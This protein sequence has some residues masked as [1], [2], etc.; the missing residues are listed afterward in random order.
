MKPMQKTILGM[1]Q[2]QDFHNDDELYLHLL[3]LAALLFAS[4]IHLFLLAFFCVM[5]PAILVF[6]NIGSLCIYI[7]SYYLHSKKAYAAAGVLFTTEV[8]V[9]SILTILLSGGSGNT[10]LYFFLV[11]VAQIIIPYGKSTLRSGLFLVSWVLLSIT[12]FIDHRVVSP[13]PL[14]EK[15]AAILGAFNIQITLLG[16]VIILLIGDYLRHLIADYNTLR[17]EKYKNQAQV[18]PLTG[19]F[20]RHYANALWGHLSPGHNWAV[21][22]LDIDDFKRINDSYGHNVGDE[23]LVAISTLITDSLRKSD[24]VIRWGGEEFL[25]LLRDVDL[26]TARDILA[27]LCHTIDNEPLRTQEHEIHVTVS[28]GVSILDTGDIPGSISNSDQKLYESKS[29]GKNRVTI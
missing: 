13:F 22:M 25:I 14:S 16:L 29:K 12:L 15:V 7:I 21:A 18:D 28:I 6:I 27:K 9:Y 23:V 2:N 20:N 17:V 4:A 5:G 1:L 19:Q 24:I 10:F 11:A 8:S 3:L 26:E